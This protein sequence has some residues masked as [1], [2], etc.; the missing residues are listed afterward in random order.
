MI[1]TDYVLTDGNR[2]C[3]KKV[4]TSKGLQTGRGIWLKI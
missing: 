4:Q 1:K 3:M 2:I